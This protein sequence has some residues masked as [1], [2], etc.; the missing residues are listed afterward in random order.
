MTDRFASIIQKHV[1]RHYRYTAAV[2]EPWEYPS[3]A[4]EKA[5]GLR[6]IARDYVLPEGETPPDIYRAIAA[7]EAEN[8]MLSGYVA[9]AEKMGGFTAGK[10]DAFAAQLQQR[11]AQVAQEMKEL[12]A[13][14]S[15]EAMEAKAGERYTLEYYASSLDGMRDLLQAGCDEPALRA[16]AQNAHD[17]AQQIIHATYAGL[18]ARNPELSVLTPQIETMT[19]KRFVVLGALSKYNVAD[20][21][22]FS[23]DG[24]T[25]REAQQDPK[26]MRQWQEIQQKTG[27][28]LDGWI[29][30]KS[31][32]MKIL[33]QLRQREPKDMAMG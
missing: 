10:L 25:Y 20:I 32:Q 6:G 14:G 7:R 2:E 28:E 1:S 19:Q 18:E 27:A 17:N 31:T 30:S 33:Q 4:F 13:N 11:Q 24:F 9:L 8:D 26:W 5:N 3:E 21:K 29:P 15:V 12:N 16:C 22:G 23:I